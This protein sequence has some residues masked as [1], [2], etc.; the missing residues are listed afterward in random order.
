MGEKGNSFRSNSG[1]RTKI[2]NHG[3]QNWHEFLQTERLQRR[4]AK[5]AE[6]HREGKNFTADF[7]DFT[8]RNWRGEGKHFNA[9][10]QSSQRDAEE[11]TLRTECTNVTMLTINCVALCASLRT[12]RLCAEAFLV[13]LSAWIDSSN[14]LL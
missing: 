14:L 4:G 1:G 8:D 10:A 13:F 11:K 3:F 12:L 9:K 2:F 6:R 7:T 5:F